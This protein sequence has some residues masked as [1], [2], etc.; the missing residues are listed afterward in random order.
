MRLRA[1]WQKS[2]ESFYPNG[3]RDTQKILPSPSHH[4]RQQKALACRRGNVK[5]QKAFFNSRTKQR[6]IRRP[7]RQLVRNLLPPIQ[8]ERRWS[9]QTLIQ[10]HQ[11][12]DTFSVDSG[13]MKG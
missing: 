9:L 6:S 11:V 5:L 13:I 2:G 4:K 3:I 8:R 7:L 1:A 12:S 10:V